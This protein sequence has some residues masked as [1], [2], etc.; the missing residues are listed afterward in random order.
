MSLTH[1]FAFRCRPRGA[2]P[3]VLA[4]LLSR[5]G[6]TEQGLNC[7]PELRDLL[8]SVLV[9]KDTQRIEWSRLNKLL[10][11]ASKAEPGTD[12]VILSSGTKDTVE[13]FARFLTS[14]AG[15]FLKEPLV[16]EIA[17]TVDGLA[18]A[19]ELSLQRATLGL[20][21][22]PPGGA[23]PVDEERVEYAIS[24]ANVVS[25]GLRRQ[26]PSDDTEALLS[27]FTSAIQ[28]VRDVTGDEGRREELSVVIGAA[29][30]VAREV[31]ALVLETRGRRVVKS[32]F[33]TA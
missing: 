6:G 29:G 19:S 21:R 22:P 15:L 30:D 28:W 3:F 31:A 2:Y 20:V 16:R 9:S 24:F 8:I 17:E 11:L 5:S 4:Q 1:C 13:L 12:N 10:G 25:E 7:P 18:S 32:L 26:A 27:L 14:D 23:G 33:G